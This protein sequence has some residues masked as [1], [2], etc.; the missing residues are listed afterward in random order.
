M[1]DLFSTARQLLAICWHQDRRKTIVAVTLMISRAVAAPLAA[2]GL[3]WLIDA[4]ISGQVASAVLAGI[5]V[6]VLA[7]AALIMGHFA[8]IA[9]FE[10]SELNVLHVDRE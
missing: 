9:H 4:A 5:T 1:R 6:A 3:R 2:L 8:H 7:V 10:L